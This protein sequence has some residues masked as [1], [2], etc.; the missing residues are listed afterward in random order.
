[1]YE[2]KKIAFCFD[3]IQVSKMDKTMEQR[4]R[5]REIQN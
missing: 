2:R 5:V 1:M 3:I 4:I